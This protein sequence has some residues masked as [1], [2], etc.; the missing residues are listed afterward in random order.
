M[1]PVLF[2]YSRTLFPYFL[3][4][5][6]YIAL[7]RKERALIQNRAAEREELF[8]QILE[9]RNQQQEQLHKLKVLVSDFL[10]KEYIHSNGT[11]H[12]IET[13]IP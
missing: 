12:M 4:L 7:Y 6:E 2:L 10:R 11:E 13:G 3:F 5:G 1:I 8:R 9:Q